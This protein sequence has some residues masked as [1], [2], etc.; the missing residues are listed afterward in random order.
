VLKY[1]FDNHYYIKMAKHIA[2]GKKTSKVG[3]PVR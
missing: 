3:A 1:I 2:Q